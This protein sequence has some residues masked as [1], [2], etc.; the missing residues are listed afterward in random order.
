MDRITG[1]EN[2]LSGLSPENRVWLSDRACRRGGKE[3]RSGST[4]PRPDAPTNLETMLR[5]LL[6]ALVVGVAVWLLLVALLFAF[7][8][9]HQARSLLALLPNLVI[10]FRGLVGDPRVPK[11][12]KFWVWFAL[13]WAVS[14]IDLIP[15]FIPV[16]GPLDDALVAALV[17]RHVIRRT[18]RGVLLDH[19]R[20]DPSTIDW[21]AGADR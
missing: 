6:T 14:P 3:S 5:G 18:D 16:L 11:R 4:T 20:G 1:G 12:T 10:L 15:E 13:A 19:W 17:L 9:A 7:G 21:L 2:P 8:R